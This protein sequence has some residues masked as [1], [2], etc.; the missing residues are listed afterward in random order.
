MKRPRYSDSQIMA[1]L[2]Q[3]EVGTP[4]P[5]LCHQPDLLPV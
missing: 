5:E 3:A 1:I 2:K 4:V